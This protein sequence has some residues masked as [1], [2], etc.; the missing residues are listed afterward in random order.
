MTSM[1]STTMSLRPGESNVAERRCVVG[2][3]KRRYPSCTALQVCTGCSPTSQHSVAVRGVCVPEK[4]TTRLGLAHAGDLYGV[5][6]CGRAEPL[7]P[8]RLPVVAVGAGVGEDVD[9]VVPH[10][11][12]KGIGV[13]VRRDGQES[14]GA[15]IASAPDLRTVLR[16]RTQ[17]DQARV[18]EPTWPDRWSWHLTRSPESAEKSCL[19]CAGEWRPPASAHPTMQ[20]PWPGPQPRDRDLGRRLQVHALHRRH[21]ASAADRWHPGW[22]HRHRASASAAPKSL[23]KAAA[24]RRL[25]PQRPPVQARGRSGD[26]RSPARG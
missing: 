5:V 25:P 12:R 4:G 7:S 24:R 21:P 22:R 3:R 8:N 15:A 20:R 17:D 16:V 1:V 11:Q 14:M 2:V 23:P 6:G 18:G 13:G 10:L 26:S 19:D 9:T